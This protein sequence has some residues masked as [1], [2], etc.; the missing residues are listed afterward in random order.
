MHANIKGRVVGA[1]QLECRSGGSDKFYQLVITEVTGNFLVYAQWGRRSA[2]P[3]GGEVALK[4]TCRNAQIATAFMHKIAKTKFASGYVFAGRVNAA[5]PAGVAKS[6]PAPARAQRTPANEA[7]VQ[8][9][10]PVVGEQWF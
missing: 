4:H 5:I 3:N 8:W 2:L 6:T 9:I 1:E 10:S 7:P